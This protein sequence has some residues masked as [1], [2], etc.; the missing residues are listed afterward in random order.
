MEFSTK[1]SNASHL[2]VKMPKHGNKCFAVIQKGN[3]FNYGRWSE[4]ITN[5]VLL[6]NIQSELEAFRM[7]MI[8]SAH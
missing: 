5:M 2:L 6:K 8:S 1:K 7:K 3:K 4:K